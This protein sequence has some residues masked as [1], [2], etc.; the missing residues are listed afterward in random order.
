MPTFARNRRSGKRLVGDPASPRA[1]AAHH[2]MPGKGRRR[3]A[4]TERALPLSAR[5]PEDPLSRVAATKKLKLRANASTESK[6]LKDIPEGAT[7]IVL[8]EAR[9][10]ETGVVR[11]KVGIDSSPR[12]L[13]IKMLGWVTAEK[14][15]ERILEPLIETLTEH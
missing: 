12:G 10:D 1:R 6:Q 7:L 4:K 5:Y 15:G 3:R 8:H 11:A 2:I 13:A 9:N 14:D